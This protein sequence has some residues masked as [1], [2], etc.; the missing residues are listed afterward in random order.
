MIMSFCQLPHLQALE[1]SHTHTHTAGPN[2]TN[3]VLFC[4]LY[5]FLI[6]YIK[7]KKKRKK[8]QK[9]TT[10]QIIY[11]TAVTITTIF[12]L[13]DFDSDCILHHPIRFLQM[14]TIY[15]NLADIFSSSKSIPVLLRCNSLTRL[16]IRTA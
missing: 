8:K 11:P 4:L 2:S 10:V 13:H 6:F 14:C 5:S 16:S 3:T 7:K 9:I 15:P 12:D 1:H